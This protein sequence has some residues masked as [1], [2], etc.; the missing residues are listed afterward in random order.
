MCVCMYVCVCLLLSVV[1]YVCILY[2]CMCD[3]HPPQNLNEKYNVSVPI[4]LM[5]SRNTDDETRH[6]L[7]KYKGMSLQYQH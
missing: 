5:N 7:K 3:A 1:L 4:V 6:T 2:V